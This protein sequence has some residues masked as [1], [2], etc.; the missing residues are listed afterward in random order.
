MTKVMFWKDWYDGT[1]VQV[2]LEGQKAE[3]S[4]GCFVV[5]CPSSVPSSKVNSRS[6]DS[7]VTWPVILAHWLNECPSTHPE[8]PCNVLRICHLFRYFVTIKSIG[9]Y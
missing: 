8:H 7:Q 1:P 4:G 3:G 9:I 5:W 6:E 2:G